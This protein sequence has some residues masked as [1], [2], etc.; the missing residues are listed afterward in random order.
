[1]TSLRQDVC[2]GGP[3]ATAP[4]NA[5]GLALLDRALFGEQ[6]EVTADR[7]RRQAQTRREGG[8]GDRAMLGNR[9]PDPV[10]GARPQTLRLGVGP[11]RSV[12]RTV[13]SD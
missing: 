5:G 2:A 8:R 7:C 12:G 9:R 3:S 1:M 6:I 4:T 11:V 10:A 13:V